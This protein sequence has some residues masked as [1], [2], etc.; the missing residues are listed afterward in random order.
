MKRTL[1]AGL[2]ATVALAAASSFASTPV[3]TAMPITGPYFGEQDVS[4]TI[5]LFDSTQ[6]KPVLAAPN[7]APFYFGEA[8]GGSRI[9]APPAGRTP[10]G[11]R[12]R[13]TLWVTS[14]G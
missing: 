3:V 10:L 14:S 1:I 13:G 7:A 5:P 8:G 12:Q 4:S 9:P 2:L 11:T 6:A